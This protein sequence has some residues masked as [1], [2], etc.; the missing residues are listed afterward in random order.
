MAVTFFGHRDCLDSIKPELFQTIKEQIKNGETRFYVGTHGKFDTMA[1]SCLRVLKQEYASI[2][3]AVVLAYLPDHSGLYLTCETIFPEG[4]E[5][6][7]KCFAID[8]RNRWMLDHADTVIAY[9]SRLY[10]GAAKYVG[11]A[12][13]QRK[14]VINLANNTLF[15]SS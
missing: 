5:A 6:V 14:I 7:P 10:G 13:N 2:Q 4:I 3:Y 15:Q 11:K 12:T 1:L 8:Y 9:V